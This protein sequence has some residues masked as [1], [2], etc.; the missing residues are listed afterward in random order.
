MVAAPSLDDALGLL[1]TLQEATGGAVEAFEYMP[2]NYIEGHLAHFPDARAP[3]AETYDVNLLVEVG[4]TAPR[5]S[6][7]DETGAVPLTGYLED[8]LAGLME[9]GAVLDAV[10]ARNEAQRAEMW[11]RREA[12]AEITLSRTPLVNNDIA[13]PL[14]KVA[15][16]L[17]RADARIAGIDG[18]A[19]SFVVSHLGDGN[20]H[21]TVFPGSDDPALKDQIME[22]VEDVVLELGGSFSAE[23][24]IGLSKRPSMA[25]RKDPAALA[26]MRAIKRALD[27]NNILNPDK[28]LPAED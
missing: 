12:A 14:D 21:Y 10:V 19:E 18:A 6:T 22:A 24:G 17:A 25:R 7:P 28:V 23:H 13:V 15:T 11:Q 9:R 16:F 5:D 8:T 20:V 26:T 3:F 4:A 2:R 1:N 27:P